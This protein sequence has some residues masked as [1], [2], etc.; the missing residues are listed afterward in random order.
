[1]VRVIK[2]VGALLFLTALLV[3]L[4]ALLIATVGNPWPA[5]GLDELEMMTNSAVLGL[6]SVLGW[7]FWAQLVLCTLWEI[8]GALRG[9]EAPQV[10]F[11]L[12]GQQRAIRWA[13]HAILA[14]G[15]TSTVLTP[16][17]RAEAAPVTP[18]PAVTQVTHHSD[19]TTVTDQSGLPNGSEGG[20]AASSAGGVG[21]AQSAPGTPRVTTV[22]GDTLWGLAETHLGDGFRW[23]E[24]AELNQGHKMS[25]GRRFTN[26]RAIEPGWELTLPADATGLPRLTD[27]GAEAATDAAARKLMIGPGDT[28]SGIAAEETG[29]AGLWP[30]LYRENQSVVGADPDLIRPGQIIEL[31]TERTSPA[32]PGPGH[33]QPGHHFDDES[34]THHHPTVGIPTPPAQEP[35]TQTPEVPTITASADPASTRPAAAT[36][37]H[38]DQAGFSAM[39]ALL[40]SAV[41]LSFGALTLVAVNRRRQFR[42]RRPGRTIAATPQDLVTLERAV[43]QNGREAQAEVEFLDRALR[44]IAACCR[45]EAAPLPQLGAAVLGEDVLTLLFTHPA[46]GDA[47]LGW[48]ATDDARA[49]T[50]PRE[51]IL[52]EELLT[53]PAPY[54]ALV[55]IGQDEDGRTWLLDLETLGVFGIAGP[56]DRVTDLTRFL[57]AEL[58]V[59]AWSDGT[60]VLLA[61]GFGAE[62][63]SLNPARLRQVD[64]EAALLRAAALTRDATV[65]EENLDADLLG[66]RRDGELL[67]S[68]GAVVIVVPG[69]AVGEFV[70]TI[71][72]R[73]RSRVVVV[74]EDDAEP[75]IELTGDGVAYLPLWGISIKAFTLPAA[76]AAAMAALVASTRN[77]EGAPMPVVDD[78]DDPV[79][80]YVKVDGSLREEFTEQR[81]TEGHDAA[82]L[83]PEADEV[84]MATA[85]TTADDLAA[86]APSVPEETAAEI[87]ALDPSLDQDVADW[88]DPDCVR[89]KIHLLGPVDVTAAGGDRDSVP[90]IGGTIE[91]I[92]YLA[93][94][95]RGVTTERA[96]EALE[97]SGKTVQNRARDARRLLG[98]RPDGSEW[99]PDAGKSESARRGGIATYDL[100]KGPGGVLVGPD[101]FRRLRERAAARRSEGLSDLVTALSLVTGEPF[102]QLRRGGY[103]WLLEGQRHDHI[104]VSSIHDVAHLV[105]T[106]ALAEGN[107]DLVRRACEAANR[108]N[109]HSDVAWLDIAAAAEAESGR[110]AADQVVRAQVLD[111]VDEDLPARTEAVIDRRGWLAS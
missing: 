16:G 31:P 110:V 91:F 29:D 9:L 62:T 57:V 73:E 5:G 4:P 103:G 7:F 1:M 60:E 37:E 48:T 72:Q 22:K 68:A 108:A 80:R 32:A 79:R 104:M 41:C 92:V 106:R 97:W 49:W 101:L 111:R 50:L 109:P 61:G 77:V 93:C 53:Q 58:A 75:A 26:P 66:L 14:V 45:A 105:A 15:V 21:Q 84:Y 81:R 27:A 24:I 90:N 52:E 13:V 38:E 19:D 28:L 39:R 70:D 10:P 12:G 71:G 67:D 36:P 17:S 30:Q 11:V 64:R 83:L 76:D 63:L 18:S 8:P 69:R 55:T 102:D 85:A 2:A 25:D 3:G 65:T 43:V 42:L 46:V 98:T 54:P 107:T 87:E 51:T 40:A 47:P 6:V 94:Q 56:R 20:P 33:H 78:T 96:A 95:D 82:S 100:D 86:L 35:Q 99:L 23:R 74:H 89:P 44:H 59:N 34:G 88:F